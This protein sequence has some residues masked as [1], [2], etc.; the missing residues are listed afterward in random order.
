MSTSQCGEYVVCGCGD[1]IVRVFQQETLK[2]VM[3]LPKPKPLYSPDDGSAGVA[4]RSRATLAIY[5]DAIAVRCA[6]LSAVA[7][8]YSDRRYGGAIVRRRRRL[9]Q[10]G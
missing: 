10:R 5:A 3:T 7:V 6:S 4:T 9:Q 1:G 2:F 8:A